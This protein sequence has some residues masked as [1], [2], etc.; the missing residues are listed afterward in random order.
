M[1]RS[2]LVACAG[3]MCAFF[4][5]APVAAQTGDADKKLLKETARKMVE[6]RTRED[7][8]QLKNKQ[9]D[10]DAV[11]AIKM[12]FYNKAYIYY[13]CLVSIGREKFS[14]KAVAD[15]A[16]EPMTELMAGFNNAKDYSNNPKTA[17]CETK[18]RLAKEEADFPPYAFLAGDDVHLYDF[19]VMRTCLTAR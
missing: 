3:L 2:V 1:Q 11:D 13:A 12:L 19:K 5:A 6:E 16:Q 8:E 17:A 14:D 18:A 7:F 9:R 15:C 10:K 4:L